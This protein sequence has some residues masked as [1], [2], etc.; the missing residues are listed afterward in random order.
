MEGEK[1][2]D[3]T[4]D[5]FKKFLEE[6]LTQHR[7]EMMD[8]FVQILRWL[9]TGDAYSSSRGAAPFNVQMKFNILYFKVR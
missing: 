9:P 4:R 1:K 3:G 7:N 2:Y 6:S 5:P 8:S